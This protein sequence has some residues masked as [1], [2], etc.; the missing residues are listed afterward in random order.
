MKLLMFSCGKSWFLFIWRKKL[1]LTNFSRFFFLFSWLVASLIWNWI[2][3]YKMHKILDTCWSCWITARQIYRY[4]LLLYWFS[5][6]SEIVFDQ[7]ME[8]SFELKC[9][10]GYK[11]PLERPWIFNVFYMYWKK[12]AQSE[13]KRSENEVTASN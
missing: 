10:V 12:S 11:F 1:S 13:S 9:K 4:G 6:V 8:R 5:L 3:L 2:L 7:K